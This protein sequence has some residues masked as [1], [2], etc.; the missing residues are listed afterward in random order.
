MK[1]FFKD[2]YD[3]ILKLLVTQLGMT[4]FGV[5]ITLVTRV[6]PGAAEKDKDPMLLV[7]SGASVLLYLV[8]L[9]MHIWEK[10]ARDRIKVDGG[11][12][13]K[14]LYKGLLFSLVANS[15]NII[16]GLIMCVTYPFIENESSAAFQL[17]GSANDIARMIQGMYVG[18]INYFSPDATS[19]SPLLFLAIVIPAIAVTSLGYILGFSN[20]RL[21]G[22]PKNQKR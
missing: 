16:C 1:N 15:I 18:F 11:R 21:F 3:T 13:N 4:M 5:M 2:G 19:T 20:F 17:F 6:L 9:Y 7:A 22:T 12:M 10:G 8:L 14:N